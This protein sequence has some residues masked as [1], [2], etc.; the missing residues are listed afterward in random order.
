MSTALRLR[1]QTKGGLK[2][3]EGLMPSSTIAD[4]L[5]VISKA[6]AIPAGRLKVKV[7]FPPKAIDTSDISRTMS[8]LQLRSGDKITVDEDMASGEGNPGATAPQGGQGRVDTDRLLQQQL[9]SGAKGILQRKVVPADNSCLFTSINA[10]MTDGSVNPDSAEE[11]RQVIAGVVSSDPETYSEGFLGRPNPD[12]VR[13]IL[14]KDSWGGGIE[15]AILANYFETEIAVVDSQ[16]ARI[17]RF[18]EDRSFSHRVFLLYDG[19]HYDPLV[20]EAAD[21]TGSI[22]E[23]RFSSSDDGTMLQ[24]MD[25]AREAQSSGQ[26]T[27]MEQ[28]SLRCLVCRVPL[29]G[30]KEAQQHA[31]STGHQNYGEYRP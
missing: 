21:S 19:V 23:L 4:L 16:S 25:I 27:N 7:G 24:A 5:L 3:L 26:F 22:V 17:D 6:T 11:L 1:C 15:L 18:G 10:V 20:M 12:Y 29:K 14:N 8:D 31:L 13:W 28:F 2:S 30:Q 9:A